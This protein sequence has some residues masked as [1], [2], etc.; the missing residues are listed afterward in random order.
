MAPIA[1]TNAYIYGGG[2][3]FTGDSN[4]CFLNAEGEALDRSTFRS[5]GWREFAL[6]ERSVE[7]AAKGWWQ[8]A[9]S[10]AV[11]PELFNNLT[12][13][14]VFTVGPA[15]TEGQPALMFQASHFA[16]APFGGALGELA[17]F[18]L[19]T[20]GR[21][22]VG[23]VRGQLTKAK[24]AVSATGATG[25]ALN[26]GAVSGSQYL[27]AT[28]H[29][30][31]TAGTSIT[32]VVETAAASNFA[33]ATT[34]ITFGPLTAVGGTWGTRVAGSITDTWQ[35]LRITAVTGTWSVAAAIGVQ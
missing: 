5:A 11:D 20:R 8:S 14:Q 3:D 34:R 16:Y 1:L 19:T 27:Y 4:E 29:L 18:E 24:G 23:V 30:L 2:H 32:G 21:D 12:V 17:P 9:T 31:G 6:G 35:R 10:D 13:Q 25:T 26:L 15:E 33:G 7:F 22:G 28:L